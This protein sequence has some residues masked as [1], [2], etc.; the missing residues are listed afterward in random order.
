MLSDPLVDWR[1]G[2]SQCRA[3][4]LNRRA[5]AEGKYR[6]RKPT[7]AVDAQQI[8]AMAQP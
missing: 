4:N 5:K 1:V 2:R 3:D 8:R 6:G 7:A